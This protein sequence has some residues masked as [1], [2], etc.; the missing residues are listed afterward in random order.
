MRILHTAE[1]YWPT[2]CGVQEAL[3]RVSEGLAAR[4]HQVIVATTY[5][6]QRDF[7]VLNGVTV[8]QF[9]VQGKWTRGFRGEVRN[10]Q[11]FVRS[12]DGDVMMNYAAQQW[13]ADLVFPLLD[14]LACAKVFV[15]CGYSALHNW[16]WWLYFRRL[17]FALRKYDQIVYLSDNYQDKRFGDRY[18]FRHYSV[19]GN[20]ASDDEFLQPRTGF[21]DEY[22]ISTSRMFLC[23]SNYGPGKNQEMVLGAYQQATVLDST[24]VFIGTE[25][26]DYA[27]RLQSLVRGEGGAVRFLEHVARGQVVAAYHEADLFLF[28]SAVECF[29]LVIVEAMASRTPFISTD[30]GCV[31]DLPG[32]VVASSVEEMAHAIQGLADKGPE[33]QRL[34]EAGRQAWEQRYRWGKIV[35]QYEQLYSDLLKSRR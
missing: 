12:F 22:R 31:R 6:P 21:R 17:P 27:E 29:P 15:P 18:G 24:L 4:G 8:E 26:N 28:G 32:G 9:D 23:V 1:S 10:Y 16:K 33:W 20:G 35:D 11:C 7:Q 5:H 3:Q 34:A 13:S 30:V 19:I 14:E 2:V 25:F